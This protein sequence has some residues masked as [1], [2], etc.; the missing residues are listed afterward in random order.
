MQGDMR[1]VSRRTLLQTLGAAST[2]SLLFTGSA[3]AATDD[4]WTLVALPDT[5]KY[6]ELN[7]RASYPKAQTQWVVD[8]K[9]AE[10]IQFVSHEGDIVEN[11]DEEVE[12][13]RMDEAMSTLDGEVPY[14]VVTGN[15]DY[16]TLWD[17][18]SSTA[19]Y[20]QYFG[21]SRFEGRSWFG[22]N[23]P[24]D[25][26]LSTYQLFS[27]GGYDFLHLALEWEPPG[28]VDDPSTTLG[29]AQEILDEYSDRPTILTTHSYLMD[30]P[31][32][33]TDFVQEADGNGNSGE[34][35]W[36]ELVSPNPQV[37]MVLNG[38]FHDR[39]GSAKGEYHQTST[40][41]A[42]RDVYEMVANYQDY[43]HGG[44]GWLRLIRFEPGGGSGDADRIAVE[45]YSPTR[46]EYATDSSSQFGFELRFADRFGAVDEVES[47]TFQQGAG[48]YSGT[49]DTY[50]QEAEPTA[51]N[52]SAT[53]L[54]VDTSD[55]QGSGDAVHAL[56]RFEDIVGRGSGQIPPGA[57]VTRATLT[58]ETTDEGDGVSVHRMFRSW[59]ADAS[60]ESLG[61]GVQADDTQA[62][63]DPVA[64]TG[65]LSTG[66]TTFDVTAS[67]A[68]WVGD[69]T[70]HGLAF[71]PTGDDG[72]DFSSAEGSDPP[73]LTVTYTAPDD[74][75]GDVVGDADGDGD[76]DGDDVELVQ[77]HVAGYDDEIDESAADVDGDG[78]VDI[79]DAV[80]IDNM[81]EGS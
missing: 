43:D 29:W 4:P 23:G 22:G 8:N 26:G 33:R 41:D 38:H 40:N 39:G 67:V 28:S 5:Q 65:S 37:F 72:W 79:A 66:S 6:A 44:D 31:G 11:A 18:S 62:K 14:S 3:D 76:V 77:R 70:N 54:N 21:P 17:R 49:V 71:R 36:R 52:A 69:A 57:N 1:A 19:L 50:V 12:W 53:T 48:D 75:G 56:V 45:T 20:E 55:P 73:A 68:A 9:D 64:T 58:V 81:T 51:T 78:D 15:H 7:R 27:A 46:D 63:A 13:E 16:A 47:V 2:A 74:G 60:W 59:G 35:V 34:T 30:E 24:G 42:G 80:A 61:G 10:N 32:E 25:D